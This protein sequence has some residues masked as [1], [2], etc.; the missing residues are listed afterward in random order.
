LTN[1]VLHTHS[2]N[3]L[4]IFLVDGWGQISHLFQVAVLIWKGFMYIVPDAV[5]GFIVRQPILLP[6]T[7]C[8]GCGEGPLL[9]PTA[10]VVLI[11]TQHC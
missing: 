10:L 9:S 2:L 8:G 11:A 6:V 7:V 5:Q 1:R 3:P 4:T